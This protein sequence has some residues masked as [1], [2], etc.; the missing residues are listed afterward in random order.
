VHCSARSPTAPSRARTPESEESALDPG[1]AALKTPACAAAC[2]LSGH[3]RHAAMATFGH[4]APAARETATAEYPKPHDLDDSFMS[5]VISGVAS[6]ILTAVL[7]AA[8]A[9]LWRWRL[10][11]KYDDERISGRS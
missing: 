2:S 9:G 10:L 6:G 4:S 8:A 11:R 7:V 3:A 1:R 5:E